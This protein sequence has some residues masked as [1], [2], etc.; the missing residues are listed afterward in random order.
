MGNFA[1]NLNL[2]N[3]FR[4]PPCQYIGTLALTSEK[5]NTHARTGN[6]K[7]AEVW[8]L[9]RK[10]SEDWNR[11]AA[12]FYQLLCYKESSEENTNSNM[13]FEVSATM[14][15]IKKF[16]IGKLRREKTMF[17]SHF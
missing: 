16:W 8:L 7:S 11:L 3:R 4:P 5:R 2:G 14:C 10:Q 17:F 6:F 9:K 13:L 15:V 1:E 12:K